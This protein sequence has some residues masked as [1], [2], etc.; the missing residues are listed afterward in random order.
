MPSF[1]DREIEERRDIVLGV[2]LFA[3]AAVVFLPTASYGFLNWDDPWYVLHNPLVQSW[4]T[5]NLV[6]MFTTVQVRNF[7]PLT[8]FSYLVDY[9]LWERW[10]GGYHLVNV[11]LHAINTVLVFGLL[12]Q[13]GTRRLAAVLATALFAV[14]PVQVESVVWI[15]SRKGLLSGMF[16]LLSLRSWLREDRTTRD[17]AYGILF[18]GLAL[19]C[20]AIAIVVPPIVV[21]YDLWIRRRDLGTSLSRQF[22]PAFLACML[23]AVTMSAQTS[24]TGGVRGHLEH[25]RAYLLLVDTTLL[26]KYVAH[27]VWPQELSV[28][29]DPPTT[30]IWLQIG[31]ATL[32][33]FIIAI[34]AASWWERQPW[35]AFGLTTA[36]LLMVPVLNLF[37]LTTLM[38]DRYLYLPCIPL[39]ALFA[40]GMQGLV[41]ALLGCVDTRQTGFGLRRFAVA[42]TYAVVAGLCIVGSTRTTQ[43]YMQVWS[44]DLALWEHAREH[45]PRLTVV[46]IQLAMSLH[47]RG[48]ITRAID[49][50]ELAR[51]ETHPDPADA[52]RIAEK[53]ATWRAETIETAERDRTAEPESLSTR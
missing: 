21:L 15:S 49:E 3:L 31:V 45:T 13:L 20:K 34:L 5:D 6:T 51:V 4:S 12:R 27:L 10:A 9:S 38:N 25:G 47:R 19:L 52:R 42:T 17:E 28:L 41:E 40:T 2:G 30:G 39:F 26:W 44:D 29:Y 53:L 35:I 24:M 33:W 50:L 18:L 8:L 37:P 43:Q 46:R 32:G 48:Q 11:W 22:V 16:V 7:A 14:H 1:D 36:L 23:L